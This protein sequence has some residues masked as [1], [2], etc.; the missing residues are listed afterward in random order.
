MKEVE[1]GEREREE[2]R[3]TGSKERREAERGR[4]GGRNEGSSKERTKKEK[5]RGIERKKKENFF[6]PQRGSEFRLDI[7]FHLPISRSI[8]FLK[9]LYIFE[10]FFCLKSV[11]EA[12]LCLFTLLDCSIDMYNLR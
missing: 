6:L 3:V 7:C 10:E 2:E 9:K 11:Y 8:I 12:S 5:E 4:E 1:K